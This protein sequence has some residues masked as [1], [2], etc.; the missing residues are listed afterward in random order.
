[1]AWLDA[2][3]F[4]ER[5]A[6]FMADAQPHVGSAALVTQDNQLTTLGQHYAYN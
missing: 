2:Q 4:V 3:W 6:W 5:Y 1:M